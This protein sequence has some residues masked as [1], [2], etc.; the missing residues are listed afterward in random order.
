[1]KALIFHNNAL[2]LKDIPRPVRAPGELLIK[3]KKAGICSTDLEILRGYIPGYS[4]IPGHE[5]FGYIE[6][7][8]DA[9]LSGKRVTAEINCGCNA[10]PLCQSGLQRHCPDRTVLGIVNRGGAFAEYVSV[11]AGN[12]AVIPQEIPDSSAIF[13]EPLAAALEIFDQFSI[14]S[15]QQVLLLGDGRL[16][17]LIGLALC[18]RKIPMT[19]VGRHPGKLA[20]LEK[21]GA[22]VFLVNDFKPSPFDIVI[23]AS[24]SPAAFQLGLSCVRPRGTF[25][26]KS[27][28]A[29]TFPFNPSPAVVNEISIIGSRCGL[30]SKAIE[31]LLTHKPDLSPLISASYPF[32]RALEAFEK[33]KDKEVLK[34]ILEMF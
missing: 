8:D 30:F 20:L 2:S 12:V 22:T 24:G 21:T 15:G 4:G 18:S 27:T 16:A 28:Y 13:I 5:F 25:V 31:F 1:M 14:S 23:E 19:V 32:S 3:V 29:E 7:S 17:Q 33:T 9:S 11:P 34:V 10:C 6:D 26:L